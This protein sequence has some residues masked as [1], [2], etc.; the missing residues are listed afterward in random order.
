MK[1]YLRFS[2]FIIFWNLSIASTAFAIGDSQKIESISKLLSSI[3]EASQDFQVFQQPLKDLVLENSLAPGFAHVGEAL[4]Q[5]IE[6]SRRVA[7]FLYERFGLTLLLMTK[8][9]GHDVPGFDGLILDRELQPVANLSL[10]SFVKPKF[11]Q[12]L[13]NSKKAFSLMD[14]FS[15]A[16]KWARHISG[17]PEWQRQY[18][19]TVE[20]E[21]MSTQSSGANF[22]KL[23][24]EIVFQG[25]LFGVGSRRPH[26]LVTE[27]KSTAYLISQDFEVLARNTRPND[28]RTHLILTK[29]RLIT[30]HGGKSNFETWVG[31]SDVLK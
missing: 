10:K 6:T 7:S 19:E 23:Q 5:E 18:S 16:E 30:L 24:K 31:C 14:N 20:P 9:E 11:V 27:I 15:D 3:Q 25:A 17:H 29:D 8:F 22:I 21:R 4:P 13:F 12:L 28:G 1:P 26:W 2:L